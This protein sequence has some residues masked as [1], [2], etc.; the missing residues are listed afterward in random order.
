MIRLRISPSFDW[1]EDIEPF[2]S[3]EPRHAP[4]RQVIEEMLH[5]REVGIAYR[6]RAPY[7]QRLSSR[8]RS[9]PQSETLKG[10]LARI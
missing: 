10:G 2:A 4:R 6:R 5:P 8:S 9:P 7:C 1:F 3:T